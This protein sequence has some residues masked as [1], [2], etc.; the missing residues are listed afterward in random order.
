[1]QQNTIEWLKWRK[2]GIGSSDAGIIMGVS[3]YMTPLQLQEQKMDQSEP[4]EDH[5]NFIQA[6]GHRLEP[7]ARSTVELRLG[8][9]FT[10]AV[11]VMADFDFMRASVDG[12]SDDRK[13]VM[14]CKYQGKDAHARAG[15]EEM[16]PRRRVGERYWPQVQDILLV[17]GAEVLHFVSIGDCDTVHNF[18]VKPDKEY[19]ALLLK[20]C[21]KFWQAVKD[22]KPVGLTDR[23]FKSLKRG[24]ALIQKWKRTKL[25]AEEFK[26]K[27]EDVRREILELAVDQ[28]HAR[29]LIGG[30][31][32]SKQFKIGNVEYKNVPELKGVELDQYR[33][34]GTSS[35]KIEA[36]R[37][38]K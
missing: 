37:G 5:P 2:G 21:S 13:Q 10:P 6:K 31:V 7:K 26:D 19:Q 9:N 23:D 24:A 25:K 14:E 38:G 8:I 36:K 11:L 12:R 4:E 16:S 32:I 18:E 3:E 34:K 17:S 15:N 33:K 29:Y 35:W 22:R 20:E 27:L 28:G 30:V 1:M